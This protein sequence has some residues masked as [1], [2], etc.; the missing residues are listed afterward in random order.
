MGERFF[1]DLAKGLENGTVSRGRALKLVGGALVGAVVTSLF[2]READARRR[3]NAR[4]RCRRK[5]GARVPGDPAAPCRCA[6]KCETPGVVKCGSAKTCNCFKTIDG[7]GFCS[8]SAG[9]PTCASHADCMALLGPDFKCM[10]AICE[11]D[12]FCARPCTT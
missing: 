7:E 1:D 10:A 11:G 12:N 2:P 6:N 8:N 5:G 4:C 9:G 3:C